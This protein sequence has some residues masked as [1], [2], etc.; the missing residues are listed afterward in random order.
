MSVTAPAAP[1]AA[2]STA[3]LLP[4][5]RIARAPLTAWAGRLLE[6]V[7]RCQRERRTLWGL[8]E[9]LATVCN[10][11]A[12]IA[13]HRGDAR[14]AWTLCELQVRHFDRLA[15]RARQEDL[16]TLTVQPWVNIGRLEALRGDWEAALARFA[17]LNHKGADGRLCLGTVRVG[18]GEHE[19]PQRKEGFEAFL[20]TVYVVDSLKALLQARRWE[21]VDPFVRPLS[22]ADRPGLAAFARE[23]QVVAAARRGDL[24]RAR[25]LAVETGRAQQ[26]WFRAVFRLRLAEAQALSGETA[27]AAELLTSL[28]E[29]TG[30]LSDEAKSTLN[31]LYVTSRL[32]AACHEAGLDEAAC[33]VARDVYEGGRA[34]GDE[35]FQIEAL[36]VLA[37]SAPAGERGEWAAALEG[38]RA[39][40]EYRRFRRG[41]PA[42]S[43]VIDEL[44][45]RLCDAFAH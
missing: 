24:D 42:E 44:C 31:V 39:E 45:G 40:T 17:R 6:R 11:A 29:V 13:A 34:A 3:L 18:P 23:A 36:E 16:A 30:K 15:R 5:D 32:A 12:L 8:G 26:G 25:E 10:N 33:A 2:I 19:L 20:Q 9:E 1:A 38:A 22:L 27:E 28:A 4:S 41:E 43:P 21:E 37:R 35:V 14:T 7:E